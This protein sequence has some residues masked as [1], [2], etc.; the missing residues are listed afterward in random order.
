MDICRNEIESLY[1]A[2]VINDS[3]S[4]ALIIA[5]LAN[6][7]GL[8]LF[9]SVRWFFAIAFGLF[10]VATV[11][12]FVIRFLIRSH[13]L[14]L[15]IANQL[16]AEA[17]SKR[18]ALSQEVKAGLAELKEQPAITQ[19]EQLNEK[20]QSY[21]TVLNL[22]FNDG[23]LTHRRYQTAAER[24][25][26]SSVDSLKQY[27]LLSHA[28]KGIDIERLTKQIEQEQDQ[29]TLVQLSERRNLFNETTERKSDILK[30]NE[31]VMTAL[32]KS[33]SELA[34]ITTK[35]ESEQS[36]EDSLQ[37]VHTLISRTHLYDQKG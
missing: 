27:L 5:T 20:F 36:I 25:Y 29:L 21:L 12:N 11:S 6:G 16:Q 18:E 2:R 7:L 37:E 14:R 32:D 33:T 13:E 31:S 35:T 23:E 24:L 15:E 30:L 34:S 10:L 1:K 8:F 28:I 9:E 3:L 17:I 4:H 26:F 19:F 22:Q